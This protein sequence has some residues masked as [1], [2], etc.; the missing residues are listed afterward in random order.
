MR[1]QEESGRRLKVSFILNGR[2]VEVLTR[3]NARLLDVLRDD[4]G[5]T[6]TK[7]GCGIGECGACT[8]LLDGE[9]VNSCLV[10]AG[11]VEGR[12]VVTIEGLEQPGP[13]GLR[14]HP[15]QQSFID[16]HAVQC[17]FCTPG[18][19]LSAVALLAK[20][21]HPSREQIREAISGNLC[22]CT[23]YVSIVDAIE[24]ASRRLAAELAGDRAGEARPGHGG[25]V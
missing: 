10:L 25:A 3:P 16:K 15:V 14:L 20:N 5:L 8:V 23:G 12:E 13:E 1:T 6:G 4:L 17:G 2:R 21:P 22:R 9:A 19:I 24:E 11:Q 18:M 7:E